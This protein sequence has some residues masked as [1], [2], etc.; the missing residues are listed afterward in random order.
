MYS[1][2]RTDLV[3]QSSYI[4]I[5]QDLFDFSAT[6]PSELFAPNYSKISCTL[7]MSDNWNAGTRNQ[8]FGYPESANKLVEGKLKRA[9]LH[10]F[11]QIFA[12][13]WWFFKLTKRLWRALHFEEWSNMAKNEEN[14]CSTWLQ[15]IF[16]QYWCG[17]PKP[18]FHDHSPEI[19][20]FC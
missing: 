2:H 20:G 8:I 14:P 19:R 15:P 9:F 1:C 7:I 5:V 12:K 17:Y 11:G 18:W 3:V 16:P 4:T 10:F 13:F 6:E